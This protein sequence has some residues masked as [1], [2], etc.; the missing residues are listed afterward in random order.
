MKS[1]LDK[2]FINRVEELYHHTATSLDDIQI[3]KCP[4]IRHI[5][6]HY[7]FEYWYDGYMYN[8]WEDDTHVYSA[9]GIPYCYD[10]KKHNTIFKGNLLDLV[11]SD[12]V[13]PFLLFINGK[14]IKWS[15]IT[16]IKDWD[17]SYIRVDNIKDDYS[18]EATIMVFPISS[19][20]I[21]YGEDEDYSRDININGLYFD[22][23]HLYVKY[24]EY[25]AL[26]VRLEFGN[27]VIM[28]KCISS[29]IMQNSTKNLIHFDNIEKGDTPTLSNVTVFSEEGLLID[30]GNHVNGINFTYNGAYGIFDETE[31]FKNSGNNIVFMYFKNPNK[32]LSYI[33]NKEVS[34]DKII[35]IMNNPTSTP[36]DTQVSKLFQ[37]FDFNSSYNEKLKYMDYEAWIKS[38]MK[39]ISRY[40]YSLWNKIF[41]DESPIK[42]FTYTGKEFKNL[43]DRSSYVHYSRKHSD[44]IEDMAMMFVNGKLY[45]NSIDISY[46]NSTINLPTFGIKDS[47]VVEILLFLQCN[48]HILDIK[49][50]QDNPVYIH[51]EYNL[52]DSYIMDTSTVL[53]S[54]PNTPESDTGSRQ[55][56]CECTEVLR[57]GNN[58]RIEF[59]DPTHYNKRLKIVP[60]KQFRYYQYRYQ[61]SDNELESY[62]HKIVLPESFNYCHDIDSYM[63]FVN[64]KKIDKTEYTITIMNRYRPFDQLILYISTIFDDEDR[65]DIFYLPELLREKYKETNSTLKGIIKLHTDYPKF[66]ALSKYTCIVFVN[67]VKVNPL[68]IKDVSMNTMMIDT[69]YN[70]IYNVTIVEYLNGSDYIAKYLYGLDDIYS[71]MGDVLPYV[72][73]KELYPI[74]G[75]MSEDN[76]LYKLGV[77]DLD[78]TKYIYDQWTSIMDTV[79]KYYKDTM[80]FA[81]ITEREEYGNDI[82]FDMY[83]AINI[84]DV[85]KNYKDD[86]EPLKA[87]LYDIIIDYYINRQGSYT[88]KPF[89]YDFEIDQFDKDRDGNRIIPLFSEQDKLYNYNIIDLDYANDDEVS[90]G[91]TFITP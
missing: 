4:M 71:I 45:S 59:L 37:R 42:S 80:M 20:K 78:F 27:D 85:N 74:E 36:I 40:D 55:Y 9:E 79:Q 32:S 13:F 25:I 60:K 62:R 7:Q 73:A 89:D 57:D 19:K 72:E 15:D 29:E 54:Y 33:D 3:N 65:I 43:S 87:V 86:Y 31:E 2:K 69:K 76:H 63:V 49:V 50:I 10:Y 56:I 64:G 18:N 58:Y 5:K 66:Y 39:S 83:N 90:S 46:T 41:I 53:S 34:K 68:N 21:R 17:Y 11:N 91:H 8:L 48:N 28:K 47:D 44:L 30:D 75:F 51:P 24:P 67:G 38:S 23:N 6:L 52:N 16:I 70:E 1:K 81:D 12:E 82:L 35:G 22:E 77:E 26:S 14:V 61:K 88:G 84:V